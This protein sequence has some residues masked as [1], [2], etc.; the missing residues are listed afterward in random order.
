M[1]NAA[2]LTVHYGYRV[3]YSRFTNVAASTLDYK[4]S[5]CHLPAVH[6]AMRGQRLAMKTHTAITPAGYAQTCTARPNSTPGATVS[7]TR[8]LRTRAE[9]CAEPLSAVVTGTA[10]RLYAS[11]NCASGGMLV[12]CTC[13]CRTRTSSKSGRQSRNCVCRWR[14]HLSRVSRGGVEIEV[15]GFEI[16]GVEIEG[17]EIERF[18]CLRG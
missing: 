6:H 14:F 7:H 5:R 9:S 8:V 1:T 12:S 18:E 10:T 17:F 2:F 11:T 4:G 3:P 16:E 15:E 13:C